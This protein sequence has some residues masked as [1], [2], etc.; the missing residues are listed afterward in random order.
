V[1]VTKE[2]LHLRA[3][4]NSAAREGNYTAATGV[5]ELLLEWE[6]TD[7]GARR[8]DPRPLWPSEKRMYGNLIDQL[9]HS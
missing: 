7:C 8:L 1:H 5:G 2:M 4:L 6:P 9:T 3:S